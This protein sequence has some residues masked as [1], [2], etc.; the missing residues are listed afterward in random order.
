MK[1]K[2]ILILMERHFLIQRGY[3]FPKRKGWQMEIVRLIPIPIPM[4]RV[5]VTD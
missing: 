1:V 2:P 3:G 4:P 5:R